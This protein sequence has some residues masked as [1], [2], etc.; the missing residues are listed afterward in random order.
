MINGGDMSSKTMPSQDIPV[1]LGGGLGGLLISKSLS[2]QKIAHVLV[3]QGPPDERPRLG[4]SCNE[5]TSFDMWGWLADIGT[6]KYLYTKSHIS[7]FSGRLASMIYISDPARSLE[8]IRDYDMK[9]NLLFVLSC[10]SHVNRI[11]FDKALYH[12]VVKSPYCR[13]EKARAT[14][15]IHNPDSDR[16]ESIALDNDLVIRQPRFV[17]D[18]THN[19]LSQAAKVQTDW[20][21]DFN[22]VVWT[23][24]HMDEAD[25]SQWWRGGTNLM[26]TDL[27]HDN[28]D[29]ISWLI[30]L[31][32]ILSVG[33]SVDAERYPRERFS[34]DRLMDLTLA[35]YRHRG[36]DLDTGRVELKPLQELKQ[37][38]FVRSRAY[39]TNW[40]LAGRAFI[41]VWF[42][43]SAG[44]WT[45][46]VAAHLA[47]EMLKH[48]QC[49]GKLYESE[50]R[51][52]LDFHNQLDSLVSGP[53]MNQPIELY[54]FWSRWLAGVPRRRMF[55]INLLHRQP[56]A[57][58]NL[59]L[60]DL[61]KIIANSSTLPLKLLLTLGIFSIRVRQPH[62]MNNLGSP[63][64]NYRQYIK[65]GLNN[66]ANNLL[67]LMVSLW[68]HCKKK[69]SF[70]KNLSKLESKP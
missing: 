31:G 60:V 33:I 14:D 51:G 23:H 42:P 55:H 65:F 64:G 9:Q 13:Y 30:P 18:T 57:K 20:L 1:I 48:P 12:S 46:L 63:M 59:R 25:V 44:I 36:V 45:S 32:K 5:G 34:A 27:E 67:F 28:F 56:L 39:G 43:S 29:G 3:G 8:S 11:G 21:S 58:F 4:E 49:Y 15:L 16:I 52:L 66:A 6:E 41:Q 19:L 7:L 68:Q 61:Y 70:T 47:P 38:Y 40:L 53:V 69:L 37:R 50:L 2:H 24:L 35:A 54:H 26:R 17:F 22:R 10:L 62:S